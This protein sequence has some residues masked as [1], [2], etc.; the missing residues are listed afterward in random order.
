[1]GSTRTILSPGESICAGMENVIVGVIARR[2]R[3]DKK[4]LMGAFIITTPCFMF[5][6]FL[7]F[8]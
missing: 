5:S 8:T 1:M 2:K 7:Y 6:L 4:P 3:D